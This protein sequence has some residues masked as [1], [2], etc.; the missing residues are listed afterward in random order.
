M[1]KDIIVEDFTPYLKNTDLPIITIFDKSTIDYNGQ[2][3][4]RLFNVRGGEVYTSN[5]VCLN[6]D[7]DK[8]REIMP[9]GM[10]RVIR[11]ETDSPEIIESYF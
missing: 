8:L 7:L 11:S 4:A 10:V 2:Y 9:I 1:D 3:V 6:K 5:I